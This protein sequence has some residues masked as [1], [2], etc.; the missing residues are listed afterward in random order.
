MA[1]NINRPSW[2]LGLIISLSTLFSCI[3]E[4]GLGNFSDLTFDRD[5][6]FFD[7]VF[8]QLGSSTEVLKLYNRGNGRINID[9]IRL[10]G[11]SVFRFNAN[12]IPGPTAGS[13]F[14]DP[15]DSLYVFIEVT[16]DPNGGNSPLIYEDSLLIS[17]GGAQKKVVLAAPGQ[18]ALYYLPTDTLVFPPSPGNPAG[19][20]L[21]YRILDCAT[22]WR[23]ER[24]VVI[25]GYLV[26]DSTC[27]LTIQPGT[28]VHFFNN[29]AL[30]VYR[31]GNLQALGEAHQPI[32]FQGTRLPQA[33]A[34]QP[35]QWDRILINDGGSSRLQHCLIKN[36][37]IGLQGDHLGKLNGNAGAS[38][39]NL[40]N[41]EIRNSSGIGLYTRG[42][43]VEA[44][45]LLI[46]NC[47]QYGAA[48]TLG[49]T[50][51]LR[52]ATIA[53]YWSR[54]NRTSPS[55][56]FSNYALSGNS[57]IAAPLNLQVQNSIVYGNKE[58]EL[59]WDSVAAAT[60]SYVFDHCL[61]KASDDYPTPLSTRFPQVWR[62]ENPKF[63]NTN[64]GDYR[65]ANDGG[66]ANRAN[67][68]VISASP[69]LLRFDLRGRNRSSNLPDLGAEE[70][71]K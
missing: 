8:T 54:S 50:I 32:V 4:P 10:M 31:G 47:G 5:T 64:S 30:W 21:P 36:A 20:I 69:F 62:N 19:S 29:G 59:E 17:F 46:H 33:W 16:L 7:T 49:G 38:Q 22:E 45:N 34:E 18:D 41:V 39:L 40:H 42:L 55:L 70:G 68:G 14:I 9:E 3:E 13:F 60:F 53:N 61:I 63:S 48:F 44:S 43:N 23:P 26:V 24:P 67:P 58:S 1:S 6:V 56:F 15:G 28:Q 71:E 66:A 25:V 12:G 52:H 2:I 65:P 51:R 11:N 35:G 57:S 27:T 37:F